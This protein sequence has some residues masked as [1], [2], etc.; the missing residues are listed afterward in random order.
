VDSKGA[1]EGDV[2]KYCAG[3]KLK[4]YD[5]QEY[6]KICGFDADNNWYDCIEASGS[7][8]P[9][10]QAAVCGDDGCGG[11]C[12]S[13]AAGLSCTGGQCIDSGGCGEVTFE[14]LCVDGGK[15]LKYCDNGMLQTIKCS[16]FGGTCQ[17]DSDKKYYN[18]KFD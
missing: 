6:G 16:D 14:G 2:L 9:S 17:Y 7:C 5:C 15:T 1:C 3:D 4:V 10:C 12:G 13:C 18:C 8:M 11:F